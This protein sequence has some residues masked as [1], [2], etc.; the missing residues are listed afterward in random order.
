MCVQAS[1]VG[2]ASA[3]L[4]LQMLPNF[5]VGLLNFGASHGWETK[6]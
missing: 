2:I 1:A 4:Y 6:G 5:G 3:H